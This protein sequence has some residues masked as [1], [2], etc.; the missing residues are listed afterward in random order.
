[1]DGCCSTSVMQSRDGRAR[2]PLKTLPFK[3]STPKTR[4]HAPVPWHLM[5]MRSPAQ[6]AAQLHI[7]LADPRII[8]KSECSHVGTTGRKAGPIQHPLS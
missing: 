3:H 8:N 6:P 4:E 5:S 7:N 2:G 1:M